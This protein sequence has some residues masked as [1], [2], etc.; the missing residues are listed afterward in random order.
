[1][2]VE[3]CSSY[4]LSPLAFLIPIRLNFW[5]LKKLPSYLQLQDGAPV[6]NYFWNA[7]TL[8][9]KLLLECDNSNVVKWVTTP[10]SVLLRFSTMITQVHNTL[11][12][13]NSWHINHIPRS[14]NGEADSLVKDGVLRPS[15]FLWI[16]HSFDVQDMGAA[17]TTSTSSCQEGLFILPVSNCLV[18]S[19]ADSTFSKFLFW[20]LSYRLLCTDPAV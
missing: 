12:R 1:M 13:I 3:M 14:A 18:L 10:S 19:P 20:S 16:N 9:Y 15:A 6:I 7:I 2:S 8:M 17:H 11:A 4:S 5:P